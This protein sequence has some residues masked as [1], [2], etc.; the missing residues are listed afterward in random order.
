MNV[1]PAISV[2]LP[3]Y[4]NRAALETLHARLAVALAGVAGGFELLFVNDDCPEGS[5]SVLRRLADRDARV[6]VIGLDRRCGQMGALRAG[7]AAARGRTI[8]TM[9]ADL[10]DPPEAIPRLIAA[11]DEGGCAA[12]YAGRRGRY[13]SSRRLVSSWVFKHAISLVT[14]MPA[15]AGSFVAMRREVADR[16]LALPDR[17]PYLAGAV[18]WAGGHVTSVPV[19]RAPRRDGLVVLHHGHAVR[20]RRQRALAGDRLADPR[21]GGDGTGPTAVAR[22]R[23]LDDAP[24]PGRLPLHHDTRRCRVGRHVDACR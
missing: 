11:L 17:A 22:P 16:I 9:D 19:E 12:V 20:H 18:A 2:V 13:E 23:G 5:L 6:R 4:R 1:Q 8:V 3:V 7:I 24:G 15:D 21:S 10:Q 14:G